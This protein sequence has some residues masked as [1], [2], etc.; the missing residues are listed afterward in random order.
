[1]H[2]QYITNEKGVHQAVVIPNKEWIAF[3]EEYNKIKMKLQIMTGIE[4]ALKEVELIKNGKKKG[5]SLKSFLD[6]L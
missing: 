2:L 3:Q 6:E 5:K 1:M 4:N